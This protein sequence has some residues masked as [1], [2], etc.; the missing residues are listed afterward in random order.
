MIAD[1]KST[2]SEM[3]GIYCRKHHYK[4]RCGG[5]LCSECKELL[6]YATHRL[7]LCPHGDNKPS[8]RHCRIHCY[9]PEMRMRVRKVMRYAGPRML[10]YHPLSI[11]NWVRHM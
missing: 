4:R 8:C 11:L 7:D 9:D 1:E 6:E 3:I 5:E 2:I 10:L